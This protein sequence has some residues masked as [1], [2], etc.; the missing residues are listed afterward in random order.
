MNDQTTPKKADLESLNITEANL[1]ALQQLLPHVFEEGKINFDKLKTTLG[2][3]IAADDERFGLQWPGKRDVWKR[4]RERSRATLEPDRSES[5]N[6]DETEHLF[7][8]GDNLEVLKLLQ[9]AYY[10]KVKMIYIDPPYNTGKEFVYPDNYNESLE[11]YLEYTG[12]V[13]KDGKKFKT[14]TDTEGRYHSKWLNMMYPRLF[15]ARNLLTDDGVM[16]ISIDDH[17]QANLKKLCDEIFGEEN[18]ISQ[19]IWERA[20]APK[21]DAKYFSD[22]HDFV[23]V[24]AKNISNLRFNLL[25]RTEEANARY[26]N[27][28]NDPRGV[29]TSGDLS[30][31]TYSENYDYEITTPSGAK[32]RPSHGSC[33][34]VSF[35]KLNE[36]IDDNRIWFGKDGNN[37][38]RLKRFLSEVQDGI[39]PT[40]LW[41]HKD[42]GHNQEGRQEVKKLFDDKGYFDGPKPTRL[43]KR[44]LYL[45][46]SE[47]D[48]VLDF[49]SGS[50]STAHAVLDLNK[51]DG[52]NRKFIMVQLPEPT[53]EKSDAHKAGYHTIADIGKERIR[54]VIGQIEA[55]YTGEIDFDADKRPDLGFRVFKL[56][57]SNFKAWNSDP[58]QD[59]A[60]TLDLFVDH[61]DPDAEQED[62]LYELLLKAG[63]PLTVPV[64]AETIAGKTVF[65][66]GEGVM[67]ICLE[68][69]LTN[70]LIRA[71]AQRQP[72]RVICLDEGF[73]GRDELLSN[74]VQIMK[75]EGVED[76]RT[77]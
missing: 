55:E 76:F 47:E 4:I 54:R 27:L 67:F 42:V 5:V 50:A 39:V 3:H 29:W 69:E 17:E 43:I 32:I 23:L 37:V 31:K 28:D 2:D 44:M 64:A 26:K 16:F 36:L 45:A 19:I 49:F 77:I 46:T 6:F 61:I 41:F 48:I 72:V 7:L 40:S 1:Q 12:Q 33:W 25:E 8:E 11:T 30:V 62:L 21:N 70:E 35:E 56:A 24:Y 75:A 38:P 73:K 58:D 53:D 60:T 13:D 20:F 68:K 59:L 71:I 34:R 14:N 66:I 65:N 22:N 18:F 63:F 57:P 15:L 9:K 10:G 52:G 74:A 51:E